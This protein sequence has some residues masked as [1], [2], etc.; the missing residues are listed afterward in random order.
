MSTIKKNKAIFAALAVNTIIAIMKF[1]VAAFSQS[2]SMFSEAIHSSADTLNQVVLLIGKRSAKK[3]P[4]D[5]HPFGHARTVFFASFCVAALLFFVGGAYSCMEAIEKISH[6]INQTGKHNLDMTALIVAAG[7]LVIS[8]LLECFS[9][10][11]ALKEVREEQEKENMPKGLRKFYKDTRNSSL[12]VI[13]TE[14]LTAMLGLG[15]ALIGVVLTL[16]TKNPLWDAIGGVAIGV[17]LIFAAFILGKEIAS[18]IIGE[19]LSIE[20]T[21]KIE[22][23]VLATPN[24]AGCRNVKTVAIGSDS[25]LIEIDAE[26]VVGELANSVTAEE[27]L[28]ATE[29]IKR[30]VKA[31]WAD[32]DVYVSTCVEAVRK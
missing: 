8:I 21:R 10:R 28:R 31:L 7:I 11:T 27:I 30:G 25:I 19:S 18:L 5:E 6:T 26:F 24:V 12:I 15:L 1:I 13:V 9:F 4:D 16:I 29:E 20:N 17:L 3:E 32:E 22:A 23:V 14:D 2:A